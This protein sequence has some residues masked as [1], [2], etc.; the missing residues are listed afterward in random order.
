MLNAA[1]ARNREYVSAPVLAGQKKATDASHQAEVQAV[2]EVTL[3]PLEPFDG[4][5]VRVAGLRRVPK[6]NV[7]VVGSSIAGEVAAAQPVN[8]KVKGRNAISA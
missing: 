4:G 2:P 3:V 1:A 8:E 6:D 5:N 7:L